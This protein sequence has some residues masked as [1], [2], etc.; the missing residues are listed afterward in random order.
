MYYYDGGKDLYVFNE[1]CNRKMEGVP[2]G[3]EIKLIVPASQ[4]MGVFAVVDD[5]VYLLKANKNAVKTSVTLQVKPS[6]FASES[7][8]KHYYAFEKGYTIMMRMQL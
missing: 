6:A 4:W 2:K 5:A 7:S 3:S 1:N 8:V